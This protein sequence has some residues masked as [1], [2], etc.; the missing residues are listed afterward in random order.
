MFLVSAKDPET[1]IFGWELRLTQPGAVLSC[2][3]QNVG[4]PPSLRGLVG[5]ISRQ[6]PCVAGRVWSCHVA[7]VDACAW[8]TD[9]LWRAVL[10]SRKF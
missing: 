9:P 2:D 3:A 10:V 6:L 4:P 7:S 1:S 5:T 8:G